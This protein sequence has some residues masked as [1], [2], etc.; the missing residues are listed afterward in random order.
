VAAVTLEDL[1]ACAVC[2]DG[3]ARARAATP[4]I[5]TR[6]DFARS[7]DAFPIEYGEI[8]A[9][10]EIAF[11]SD[12][13][14][15]LSIHREDL[16]RACEVQAKSHM[17]HLR[18]DYIESRGRRA[19][20]DALVRES[21]PAFEA[22]LRNLARLDGTASHDADL[23]RHA[24]LRIGLD[25]RTVDDLLALARNEALGSVDAVRLFPG[26]LIAME[27]LA[28]FVDAWPAP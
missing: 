5:L 11:G 12:P 16:R 25:A 7:L 8:L 1:D 24:T 14:A 2:A 9:T 27:R 21:A 4:L 17:L 28:A 20:I 22:L 3:W 10:Y 6:S 13:F 18:E 23:V 15:G 26:Y 19:E